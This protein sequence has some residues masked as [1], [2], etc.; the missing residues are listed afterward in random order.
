MFRRLPEVPTS[1]TIEVDGRPLSAAA[2]DSVAAA[3]LAGG[4]M[5][6]RHHA[7]GGEARAPWCLVGNCYECL[8]EIDGQPNR[9]SCLVEVRDGMRV[10]RLLAR[11]GDGA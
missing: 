6:F 1:V 10:R 7:V 4:L 11:P 2:G 5:P 3:L 9:Q 8:L